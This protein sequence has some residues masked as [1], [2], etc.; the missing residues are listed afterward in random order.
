MNFLQGAGGVQDQFGQQPLVV[1]ANVIILWGRVGK[2]YLQIRKGQK[3]PVKG[4]FGV[5]QGLYHICP[6]KCG[7]LHHRIGRMG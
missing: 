2:G 4:I 7:C 3:R 5:V 6:G 1:R